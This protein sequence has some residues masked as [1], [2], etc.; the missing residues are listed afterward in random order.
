MTCPA[1]SIPNGKVRYSKPPVNGGYI[2]DTQAMFSC[3]SGYKLS[4]SAWTT[5]QQPGQ[6]KSWNAHSGH[7]KKSN[8]MQTLDICISKYNIWLVVT[9]CSIPQKD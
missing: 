9:L 8:E 7:C 2:L 3:N 5:C 4:G 6:P 1:F